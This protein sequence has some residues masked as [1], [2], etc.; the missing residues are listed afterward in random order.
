MAVLL[1]SF[2]DLFFVKTVWHNMPAKQLV[3]HVSSWA[4]ARWDPSPA[5]AR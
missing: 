1:P 3:P 2:P 4:S 5:A